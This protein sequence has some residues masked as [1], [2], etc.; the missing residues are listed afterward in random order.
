MG[1]SQFDT[2]VKFRDK[3]TRIDFLQI[4]GHDAF[5]Y[6]GG[7]N[8]SGAEVYW[9]LLNGPKTAMELIDCTGRGKKLFI[10]VWGG[11]LD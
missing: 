2:L 3:M 6:G 8:K 5:R 1:V 11:C 4:I 7:L 10:D 9:N